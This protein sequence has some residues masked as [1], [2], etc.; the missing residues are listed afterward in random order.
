MGTGRLENVELVYFDDNPYGLFCDIYNVEGG[1]EAFDTSDIGKVVKFTFSDGTT[2]I[3]EPI[4]MNEYDML[5][6][7]LNAEDDNGGGIPTSFPALYINDGNTYYYP[8][9]T[10][11]TIFVSSEFYVPQEKFLNNTGLEH[12]WGKIK[13]YVNGRTTDYIVDQGVDTDSTHKV[14]Y[15]KW[16]SGL[17]EL[18][19]SGIVKPT[20][21]TKSGYLYISEALYIP[22][23]FEVSLYG[24]SYTT[25]KDYV[26]ANLT[27]S[28]TNI[29]RVGL[30]LNSGSAISTNTNH[31]VK[32]ET[33]GTWK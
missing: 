26:F 18:S 4:Y 28:V 15:R 31:T 27:G 6:I 29:S 19:G 1:Y 32:F 11:D 3:S 25:Q 24:I 5:I 20:S 17:V 13:S 21:S 14:Y 22:L 12:L 8:T 9:N 2:L 33:K 10:P 23:P 7:K 30:K 16:N